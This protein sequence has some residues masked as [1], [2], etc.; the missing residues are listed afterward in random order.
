MARFA[1]IEQP[2]ATLSPSAPMVLLREVASRLQAQVKQKTQA[3]N[4]LHNLLARVF[5]ELATL[6]RDVAVGWVLRLLETYPTAE[7]IAKAHLT[8]LEKIPFLPQAKVEALHL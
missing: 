5:P 1:V 7:R 6:T 2:D 8:S 3:V 4:R